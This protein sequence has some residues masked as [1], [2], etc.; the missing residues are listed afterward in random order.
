[1]SDVFAGPIIL[2]LSAIVAG[3][4]GT[5]I[6]VIGIMDGDNDTKPARG[7]IM[8]ATFALGLAWA[9]LFVAGIVLA[10]TAL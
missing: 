5:G 2:L 1:M 9:W 7:A 6:A 8:L 4:V 3:T 10:V